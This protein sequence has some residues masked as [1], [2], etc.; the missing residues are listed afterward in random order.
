MSTT[1]QPNI[2]KR[3]REIADRLEKD[4]VYMSEAVV[5]VNRSVGDPLVLYIGNKE[6]AGAHLLLHVGARILVDDVLRDR[7]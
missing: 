4:N 2:P 1:E 5:V 7:Y 3:L 6:A